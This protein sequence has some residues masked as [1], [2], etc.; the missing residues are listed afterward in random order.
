MPIKGDSIT[1][2]WGVQTFSPVSYNSFSVG[3][4]SI[5]TVIKDDETSKQAYER[6]WAYLTKLAEAS[7]LLARA[8]YYDKIERDR[9]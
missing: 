5:T 3:P 2:T 4:F 8:A 9:K 6:A 7:Y 1:V